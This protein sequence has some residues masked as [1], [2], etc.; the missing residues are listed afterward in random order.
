MDLFSLTT[1]TVVLF[2][3]IGAY[4][5]LTGQIEGRGK[6]VLIVAVLVAF[7]IIFLNLSIFKSYSE[8]NTYPLSTADKVEDITNYENSSTYSLSMWIFVNDWNQK[9]GIKKIICSRNLG[10]NLL[11]PE[12][13]LDQNR[14]SLKIDYYTNSINAASIAPIKSTNPIEVNNIGIQKWNCIVVC[15]GDNKI[16]TYVNGKLEKSTLTNNIQ[17][18]NPSVKSEAIPFKF[19]PTDNTYNG[20]ISAT[21]YYP[22]FLSPQEVWEIYKQGFSNN[23]LGNFLNQYNARFTFTKDSKVLADIP[24]I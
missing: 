20:Y 24:L 15:F 13:Y 21:R 18:S 14:N 7:I 17:F 9:L 12:I 8:K 19:C 1:I 5:L 6:I 23:L 3:I 2:L 10:I 16:D 22:K 4:I 11:Q